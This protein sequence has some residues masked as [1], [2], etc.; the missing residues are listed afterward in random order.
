ME[1]IH[2]MVPEDDQKDYE[3]AL[4]LRPAGLDLLNYLT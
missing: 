2:M 3:Q 1:D 4:C